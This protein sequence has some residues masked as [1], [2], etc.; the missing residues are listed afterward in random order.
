[1]TIDYDALFDGLQVGSDLL[2]KAT[3]LI[4]NRPMRHA[5]TE[6]LAEDLNALYRA[7]MAALE[8]DVIA[9]LE[10][11]GLIEK[12]S[13]GM[14]VITNDGKLI[15]KADPKPAKAPS[16]P[17]S[18][19]YGQGEGTGKSAKPSSSTPT[20]RKLTPSG[21]VHVEHAGSRGGKFWRDDKGNVRYGDRPHGKF[22]RQATPDAVV[23][24][25]RQYYA[26]QP[27]AAHDQM[28]LHDA[29][30]HSDVLS[31]SDHNFM[32]WWHDNYDEVL[33]SF[34]ISRTDVEKAGGLHNISIKIGGR[35]VGFGEAME[36]FFKANA[37][38]FVG[39]PQYGDIES[40]D[41]I[42]EAVR[43]LMERYRKAL[44]EDPKVQAAAQASAEKREVQRN[45]FYI[46]AEQMA[47][48]FSPLAADMVTIEDSNELAV[49]MTVAMHQMGLIKRGS[50]GGV[51]QRRMRGAITPESSLLMT[52]KRDLGSLWKDNQLERLNASQ[53]MAL[54]VATDAQNSF[55][56]DNTYDYTPDDPNAMRDGVLDLIADKLG[57]I[58]DIAKNTLKRKL[59]KTSEATL[60]A[61]TDYNTGQDPHFADV[62]KMKV[63][64]VAGQSDIMDQ[65]MDNVAKEQANIEKILAAQEDDSF[66]PP[67]TMKNGIWNGKTL[68]DS[69]DPSKG[70][71]EPFGYQKKYINWMMAVKR[72]II[73]AD[74]GLGKTPIVISFM[75]QL[76]GK[77][78]DV[79][80]ICF[81]PP[82][83]MEQ[84]PGAIAKFA[85][86]SAQHILNLSGLSLEERKVALQSDLAKEA[87]YIFISSGTL[88]GDVPD[89][90]ASED[91]NDGT[92]G[93]D[94]EMVKILQNLEG[95]VF[96]DEAHSGGYKK[97]GNTRH[98]IAKAVMQDREYAFGMT[99]TPIPN[100]PMDLYHLSN[101]FAPGS[102]GDQELWS[103]RMAGVAWNE[104]KQSYDV[105]N[106]EHLADLNKRLK[107]YVF[108]KAITDPDVVADMGKGLTKR[109]GVSENKEQ[110]PD[111]GDLELS[112][113]VN[114]EN[115]LSQHD[116]F[117]EDGV[118]DTM[119]AL[120]IERLIKERQAKVDAGEINPSTGEKYQPHEEG[121]LNLLAGGMQM[122]LQRQAS[123][124]PALIDPTY[125]KA[126]GGVAHTPKL[127]AICD[128]I[129]AHFANGGQGG[130][131]AKGIVAFC[132][133]PG[134]AFPVI[135]KALAERGVD[136][137]LIDTIAGDVA[138]AERGYIQDKYNKGHTKVALI[139]TISGGAGLNLQEG[140]NKTLFIDEPWNPAAKRQ[141][142]GR[143]WRT[144]QTVD[145]HEKTYRSVGTFDMAVEQKIAG[146]QAM[147]GALLGKELPTSKTFDVEGT[148]HDL[149]RRVQGATFSEAQLKTIMENAKSYD[150]SSSA[151]KESE[152]IIKEDGPGA[153]KH[154]KKI[155]ALGE[156]WKE[157]AASGGRGGLGATLT[158]KDFE[159][160]KA[161]Q[162]N[163]NKKGAQALTKN[164]D[165]TEFR[166]KWE[167]DR[168]KRNSK[169]KF[170]M[171]NLMEQIYKDKGDTDKAEHYAKQAEA[172]QQEYP[173]LASE[174][175]KAGGKKEAKSEGKAKQGA[176][177]KETAK[178]AEKPKQATATVATAENKVARQTVKN[179][180]KESEDGKAPQLPRG[181]EPSK[182]TSKKESLGL[183]FHSKENPFKEGSGRKI[184]GSEISQGEAHHFFDRLSKTRSGD[185]NEF[186]KKELA[187]IWDDEDGRNPFSNDKAEEYMRKIVGALQSQGLLTR[188][189]AAFGEKVQ[190]YQKSKP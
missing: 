84:W 154:A 82:S 36:E 28:D 37:D 14:L 40:P 180:Q 130:K 56:G 96:I 8:A 22:T 98:E 142:I 58:D 87:R 70:V 172:L 189:R 121:G 95:A 145:V 30:I 157:T 185:W 29:L 104:E 167:L 32:E 109:V 2:I 146:K 156:D 116:Y 10:D 7:R 38:L 119:V 52:R 174:K 133:F 35:D 85:P 50:K 127:K 46:Q 31:E 18:N 101:L 150:L 51:A 68:K 78:K 80:A 63:H 108:Y 62:F 105:S 115:G 131:A 72:G 66:E 186:I 88:T 107:P 159:P 123:I 74:A 94:H 69:N 44:H 89:P 71:W 144:G 166:G 12:S 41:D 15:F 163:L 11:D 48:E 53:L 60:K 45:A 169:Q 134:K 151:Q 27:F 34:G 16:S 42:L 187:P 136:P 6:S 4:P 128:D 160:N 5:V 124:S 161:A 49:K 140:G 13:D 120:R 164:F 25:F 143:Q 183:E 3:L 117:K 158:D 152:S 170:Q 118:I 83:L 182:V 114:S 138:P 153:K 76:R 81:L 188:T 103:G 21:Y 39:D 129:I 139:G 147:V 179:Q 67:A 99:A 173:E 178:P 91:E 122:M 181:S 73:A 135:R 17:I 100:D 57:I 137:S 33:G 113:V 77:G 168:N 23:E 141:A 148:V 126:D 112:K 1:M 162:A 111:E 54:Y 9:V 55:S 97:A 102:V 175:P 110:W 184:K 75:E 177:Q 176:Q 86:E 61:F 59:Q 155:E 106:P 64:D 171:A 24:H 79:P 43:G 149:M 20:E 90:N 92:G 19:K 190:T 26:P 132:S 125:R 165:E 47:G 65:H 93:S